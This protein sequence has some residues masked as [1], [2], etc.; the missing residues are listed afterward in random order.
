MSRKSRCVTLEI[1]Q[2]SAGETTLIGIKQVGASPSFEPCILQ[3]EIKGQKLETIER[4]IVVYC[5]E[6]KIYFGLANMRRFF[7]RLN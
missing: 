2:N 5:L 1:A 4:H 3:K 6:N 7:A